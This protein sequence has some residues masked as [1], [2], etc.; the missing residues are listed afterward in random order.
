MDE[1]SQKLETQ[2]TAN[3]KA[4]STGR[5]VS[6]SVGVAGPFFRLLS[7]L[8]PASMLLGFSE[9]S[10]K[11]GQSESDSKQSTV[12]FVVCFFFYFSSLIY[13]F[14]LHSNTSSFSQYTLTQIFSLFPLSLL[15]KEG[16]PPTPTGYHPT[17]HIKSLQG[18]GI[19]F[20]VETRQVIG[21]HRQSTDSWT[22]PALL[23]GDLHEDQASHLLLMC[24]GSQVQSILAL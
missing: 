14:P 24:R 23:L 8:L 17:W 1:S 11:P 12:C 10:L 15:L 9:S 19:S 3:P 5:K 6:L 16:G 21:I 18:L 20:P 2:S 13:S 4:S 7:W 22:G